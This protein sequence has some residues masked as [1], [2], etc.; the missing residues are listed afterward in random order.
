MGEPG[1]GE[2]ASDHDDSVGQGDGGLN[3]ACASFRADRQFPEA[4]VVPGVGALDYPPPAGLQREPLGADHRPTAEFGQQ[5]TGR[6][7]VV[8]GI[9]MHGD[10]LGQARPQAV[11][12]PGESFRGGAQQ[13]RVVAVRARDHTAQRNP[14]PIDQHRAFG[15][16]FAAVD[17]GPA[18]GLAAAGCLDD[19]PVHGEVAKV[20]A[21]DPVV[22]LQAQLFQ[23]GEES[24]ADP[25]IA[26]GAQG[27]G[28][29]GGIGDPGVGGPE[30]QDRDELVEDDP[31]IDP[32]P[33]AAPGVGDGALRD[34]R[35]ELVPQRVDERRWQSR[36]EYLG[37]G[38]RR[39]IP[40]LLPGLVPVSC[41]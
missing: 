36:H 9:Q 29:A 31:V 40:L 12:E 32:W 15:A 4:S 8:A 18:S 27:G 6:G 34:Q 37:E 41:H 35:G 13:G 26:P 16:L 21:H 2:E 28:R 22:G 11:V 10:V 33:V 20:L 24:G 19:A 3:D 38:R 25:F 39:Q 23:A 30:D 1:L 5:V 14:A 7:T 17:R